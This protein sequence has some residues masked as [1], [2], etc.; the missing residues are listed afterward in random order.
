M[1][2]ARG[3]MPTVL[4]QYAFQALYQ[5]DASGRG[6]SLET[7]A[8][9]V[10]E[11]AG[12]GEPEAERVMRVVTPAWQG[13]AEADKAI[14][15]ISPQ[16]P[17]H[18]LAAVDR[19]ILRVGYF[20]LQSAKD[21]G[22]CKAIVSGCVSLAREYSTEKS[23]QF[24]NALLDRMAKGKMGGGEAAGGADAAAADEPLPAAPDAGEE[25]G[26][27]GGGEGGGG[28]GGDGGGD[29]D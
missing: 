21:A 16:W 1:S 28:G 6:A 24:V 14:T 26:A 3:L 4:R 29:G 23:P 20:Q 8:G 27:G 19:A 15:A 5:L 12:V 9:W 25:G 11:Q 22:E 7:V 18:R 17:A 10:R 2:G 13:R